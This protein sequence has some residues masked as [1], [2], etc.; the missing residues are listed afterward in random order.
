MEWFF[1]IVTII[2]LLLAMSAFGNVSL[3]IKRVDSL[4]DIAENHFLHIQELKGSQHGRHRAV[5]TTRSNRKGSE[6]IDA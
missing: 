5:D 1:M 2:A 4:E 3:L 6:G